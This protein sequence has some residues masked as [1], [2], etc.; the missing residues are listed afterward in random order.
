MKGDKKYQRLPKYYKCLTIS[1]ILQDITTVIRTYTIFFK[2]NTYVIFNNFS[3]KKKWYEIRVLKVIWFLHPSK[4]SPLP[5]T[6]I[7]EVKD[8]CQ[9]IFRPA[10]SCIR[11]ININSI[12]KLLKSFHGL[13]IFLQEWCCSTRVFPLSI[14]NV[15]KKTFIYPYTDILYYT[16]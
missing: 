3:W 12:T 15:C 6:F 10:G 11:H 13:Y 8:I 5:L 1:Q 2:G 9:Y 4:I 14:I 16:A 7:I